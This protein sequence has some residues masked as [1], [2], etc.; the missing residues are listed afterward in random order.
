MRWITL[1]L[2]TTNKIMKKQITLT[3][4]LLMF[5]SLV[6]GIEIGKAAPECPA[7]SAQKMDLA[8]YKGKVL[9]VDFWASWCG[10]C[11]KAMPFLNNKRKEFGKDGFE[12]IGINVDENSQDATEMLKADPVDYPVAYD[13]Q[14]QCP[15]VFEVKAMPS[16]YL[17][18]KQG[19]IRVI[20]L[21][22]R[23]EDEAT[24]SQHIAA[25]LKE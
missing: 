10:P 13:P 2:I 20:H 22:F 6:Q 24:L 15:G 14:G 17:I 1:I 8:A 25:L 4:F 11:R 18:D 23:S 12:I 21:G 19:K 16:S 7:L 3:L 9:L 5:C